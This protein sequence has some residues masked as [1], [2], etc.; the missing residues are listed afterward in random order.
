MKDKEKHHSSVRRLT[1]ALFLLII[2]STVSTIS[3]MFYGA[4]KADHEA[5]SSSEKITNAIIQDRLDQLAALTRD[6]AFWDDTINN[7]YLQQDHSWI[8]ENIGL[9][10]TDAFSISD[11]FIIVGDNHAVLS[12]R[13]GVL[14]PS[15]F[16]KFDQ[17][18]LRSLI[19]LARKSG[20]EPV[21]VSGLVMIQ[22]EIALVGI[23]ILKPEDETSLPSP[24]PVL[25]LVK[26]LNADLLEEL[27]EIYQL[28]DL[29][30]SAK[31]SGHAHHASIAL[32]NPLDNLIGNLVW[33][34]ALPGD[35]VLSYVKLPLMLLIGITLLIA[36]VVYRYAAD[37]AKELKRAHLALEYHANHDPLTGLLN[38]RMLEEFLDQ[39]IK[40]VKRNNTISALL[41]CDLDKF[42]AVNDSLG[43]HAG[44]QLL[45]DV[46][47]RLTENVR[48]SDVIARVGGDEF[49][50][51]LRNV[52][53]KN[54]IINI[55][56]KQVEHMH[57]PF[58]I[59]N[60][61]VKISISIGVA[62]IPEDGLDPKTLIMRADKALFSSKSSGRDTFRFYSEL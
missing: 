19:A 38:R 44:D 60:E 10:L 32:N 17:D 53:S 55:I 54:D 22:E 30:V 13:E 39:E 11:Q 23:S 45:K 1:V 62:M 33:R 58:D 59:F 52:D 27:V 29:R 9:Y 31:E 56:E 49:I 18:S 25:V 42:K 46:G 7:A 28:N 6:Y 8:D 61:T 12:L 26:R 34:P 16:E 37:S 48:E 20:P 21:A 4:K 41:Y 50:V 57:Q 51:L 5:I 35:A 2:M 40:Q 24:R 36:V 14:D 3:L 47:V 15:L 43:H